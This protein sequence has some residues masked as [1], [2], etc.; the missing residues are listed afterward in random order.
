MMKPIYA[1]IILALFDADKKL[2]RKALAKKVGLKESEL[3]KDYF[4]PT[5][6]ESLRAGLNYLM[7]AEIVPEAIRQIREELDLGEARGVSVAIKLMKDGKYFDHKSLESA[8]AES[9]L[10]TMIE[11]GGILLDP[12]LVPD[13]D[14]KS[15]FSE[16]RLKE[17]AVKC[18]A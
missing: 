5:F 7:M 11:S 15:L 16:D 8:E 6:Q 9:N 10:L 4:N 14:L 18:L 17:I 12:S 13:D 1:K 2:T 3:I